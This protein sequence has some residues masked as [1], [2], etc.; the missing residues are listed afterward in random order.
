MVVKRGVTHGGGGG[1]S[2]VDSVS[3]ADLDT[4]LHGGLNVVG[5]G[6]VEALDEE[7]LKGGAL[8]EAEVHVLLSAVQRGVVSDDALEALNLVAKPY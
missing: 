7:V 5:A 1:R 4:E 2:D 3:S 8:A 6:G